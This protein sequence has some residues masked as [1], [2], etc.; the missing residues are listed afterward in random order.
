MA[1]ADDV[2]LGNESADAALMRRVKMH[3]FVA[4][5]GV[6][7]GVDAVTK[8][9]VYSGPVDW[10]Q[11]EYT[12]CPWHGDP[13]TAWDEIK[14][15]RGYGA[16]DGPTLREL[17]AMTDEERREAAD[18]ETVEKIRAGAGV[19]RAE[20]RDAIRE[21]REQM[22]ANGQAVADSIKNAQEE[23]KQNLTGD[24]NPER[25]EVDGDEGVSG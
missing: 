25:I 7:L 5:G 21:A 19:S 16:S 22:V 11:E 24:L 20:A 4:A 13:C 17:R 10:T 6:Q 9:M 3:E 18:S 1:W 15:G 12:V 14:A 8:K 23:F 2:R